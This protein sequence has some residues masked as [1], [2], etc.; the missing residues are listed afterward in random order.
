MVNLKVGID[1]T[2]LAYNHEGIGNYVTELL[3]AVAVAN[4]TASSNIS[5]YLFCQP[6]QNCQILP[7]AKIITVETS[8][9]RFQGFKQ[10]LAIKRLAKEHDLGLV[11]STH[12]HLLSLLL[13]T[14]VY[15]LIHDIA[16]LVHPE[17][18]LLKQNILNRILFNLGFKLALKRT[19]KILVTTDFVKKELEHYY[20][21]TK[22]KVLVLGFG[23]GAVVNTEVTVEITGK[24]L[25]QFH[26]I[27]ER[28]FLYFGNLNPR[29]GVDILL[30]AY[31]Q[32]LI[33]HP[34]FARIKLVIAG[35][36]G[37]LYQ[38]TLDLVTTLALTDQVIFTD[39]IDNQTARVLLDHTLALINPSRYEGI[40]MPLLEAILVGKEVILSD[41]PV[42]QELY[43]AAA[44]FFPVNNSN[45]LANQLLTILQAQK[46]VTAL[47]SKS[48]QERYN[49][50]LVAI[51]F[52][53]ALEN[54]GKNL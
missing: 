9:G 10:A 54:Y 2:V 40:G 6:G 44:H 38:D 37:W 34:E 26:L 31:A 24:V 16:P 7:T 35:R 48:F 41:I 36:K 20:P 22:G 28:Y 1:V 49:W 51:N 15:W 12:T 21:V 33:D 45:E 30:Q 18:F 39:F 17:F 19:A 11:I 4:Q 13:D 43:S 47:M 46:K 14:K 27:D 52:I 50:S 3:T 25:E 29:K 23:P 42:F 32:F 53:Q 8:K 5:Y